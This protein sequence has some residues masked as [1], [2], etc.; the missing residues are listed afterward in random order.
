M[1]AIGKRV[2]ATAVRHGLNILWQP[3]AEPEAPLPVKEAAF[4]IVQEALHNVVK[5]ARARNVT[6]RLEAV[7]GAL[8]FEVSDDGACFE[9]EE[10]VAG[11]LGLQSM[12]ERASNLGGQVEVVSVP[13]QG[14]TVRGRL[15]IL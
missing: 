10:P 14:T 9:D 6:V 13:G 12:R 5:H 3:P 11:H 7:P 2:E 8:L 15:P 1:A 4:R